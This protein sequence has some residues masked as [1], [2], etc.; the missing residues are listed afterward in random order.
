M[1]DPATN[2]NSVLQRIASA[3]RNCGRDPSSI[4]LMAVSKTRPADDIEAAWNAGQR[5]FGENYL[6]EALDKI[7]RLRHLDI[8]WHFI[9]PIQS[10]KTRGIAEHFHWV[11]SVDRLK[12]AERLAAQRPPDLPPLQVCLQINIDAEDTKSGAT[13][14]EAPALAAA[15]AQW[16]QLTVRGLMCIPRAGADA[17]TSEASFLRLRQL[18][19]DIRT[20]HPELTRFDTL[21]MGMSADLEAAVAAGATIVRVGSDIFGPRN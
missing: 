4:R 9:G 3:A 19:V 16:P 15:V 14:E 21:S 6:Q 12:I 13:P 17:A 18:L 10:N 20:R 7:E 1:P 8:E 2:I 11:H 5:C